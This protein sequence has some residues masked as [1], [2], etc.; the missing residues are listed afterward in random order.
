[1]TSEG[2]YTEYGYMM[3]KKVSK[4]HTG[5]GD[6]SIFETRELFKMVQNT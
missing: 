6:V 2:K 3:T 5:L 1:M 4:E